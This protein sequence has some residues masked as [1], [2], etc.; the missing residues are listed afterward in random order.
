MSLILKNGKLIDG[1][2]NI[3][4]DVNNF[5]FICSIEN[6]SLR[7]EKTGEKIKSS[8]FVT[9]WKDRSEWSLWIYPN[10]DREDSKEY[11]SIFLILKKP[12]EANVK[13]R[14]SILNDKEEEKNVIA[15]E[16]VKEFVKSKGWGFSK[17]VRKDFLLDESNGLLINDKLTILCEGAIINLKP[18][19]YNNPEKPI[20]IT[21]PESRLL[22]EYG[23][24][25]DSPL[26]TDYIIKVKDT[27]IKVHKAV[28]AARSPVFCEIFNNKLEKCQ[29]NFMEIKDFRAEVVREMLRYI[30]TD[31]VSDIQ[32]MASEMLEI[33]NKYELHRLK[34]I[35]AK[36]LCSDLNIENVCERFILSEA[37]SSRELKDM[38][39]KFIIDNA[40]HIIKTENWD[41]L[42]KS[43]PSLLEGLFLRSIN[44]PSISN[45]T[46]LEEEPYT[47]E[48]W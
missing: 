39:Q 34:S 22:L 1:F 31:E 6:F 33:A 15:S 25:F 10:G 36:Y 23:I 18:E 3:Q 20:N 21:I 30:Y 35:A 32:N 5:N 40:E 7:L 2:C 45:N 26:F 38:V 8:T 4:T 48:T 29:T 24:M 42:V 12:D 17:F 9:G 37:Y 44:G 19:K 14:F 11:I 47:Q 41:R 13:Y 28:L 27:E 16:M 46:S 43:H